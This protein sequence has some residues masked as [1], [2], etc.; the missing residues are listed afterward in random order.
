MMSTDPDYQSLLSVSYRGLT[1][2]PDNWLRSI[3]WGSWNKFLVG[4][5]Q[6]PKFPAYSKQRSLA[7]SRGFSSSCSPFSFFSRPKRE[8]AKK[9]AGVEAGRERRQDNSRRSRT[10]QMGF[11]F[12]RLSRVHAC[13]SSGICSWQARARRQARAASDWPTLWWNI[14]PRK[15]MGPHEHLE[16]FALNSRRKDRDYFLREGNKS[17]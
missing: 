8:P 5:E 10:R 17:W 9:D 16:D 13:I 11:V 2:S 4:R 14:S 15:F 7:R 1:T 3:C 6:L 12:S